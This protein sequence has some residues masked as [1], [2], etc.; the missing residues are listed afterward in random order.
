VKGRKRG[1][2]SKTLTNETLNHNACTLFILVLNIM[3]RSGNFW[4]PL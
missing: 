2:K 3:D 4:I 1:K